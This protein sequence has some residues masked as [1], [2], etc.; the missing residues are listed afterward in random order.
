MTQHE[1]ERDEFKQ[2]L[3]DVFALDGA[4]DIQE[5]VEMQAIGYDDLRIVWDKAIAAERKR[6]EILEKA[7]TR[8]AKEK[9]RMPGY[10]N[11]PT[12]AARLAQEALEKYRSD[13]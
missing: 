11:K 7:L 10:M 5:D 4:T 9:I 6:S 1:T 12:G 13:Q 2:C 8:I 3:V